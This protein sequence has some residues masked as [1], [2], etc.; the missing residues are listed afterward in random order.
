M[1]ERI[2]RWFRRKDD[3]DDDYWAGR[4]GRS[5]RG[6][7]QAAQEARFRSEGFNGPGNIGPPGGFG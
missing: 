3:G 4:G 1:F 7:S 2:K 5:S 6:T